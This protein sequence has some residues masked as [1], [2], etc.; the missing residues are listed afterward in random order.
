MRVRWSALLQLLRYTAFPSSRSRGPG[1]ASSPWLRWIVGPT[2]LRTG[3]S[4]PRV[5]RPYSL[6][7]ATRYPRRFLLH[8]GPARIAQRGVW[9]P[10]Y[11]GEFRHGRHSCRLVRGPSRD[12]P[13][14]DRYDPIQKKELGGFV[15]KNRLPSR[16]GQG[17]QKVGMN[18]M[19]RGMTT[20]RAR[21]SQ[22]SKPQPRET[23]LRHC[24]LRSFPGEARFGF[25]IRAQDH[26]KGARGECRVIPGTTGY[27]LTIASV[28][29]DSFG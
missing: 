1:C 15:W 25:L 3:P 29:P 28:A 18:P 17:S 16:L 5:N 4:V 7:G 19:H 12:S 2:E 26:P 10:P 21:K 9:N 23:A 20:I 27:L 8:S 13:E 22:E 6:R 14:P 24:C 11:R